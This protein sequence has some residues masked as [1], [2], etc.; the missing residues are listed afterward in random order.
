MRVLHLNEHLDWVGG[1]ETYLLHLL[2]ALELQGVTCW[3]AYARGYHDLGKNAIHLPE[4]SQ[5]GRHAEESAYAKVRALIGDLK[6]DLVHIHR[7][8][9]LGAVEAC[10]EL[11]PTVVT[12]H[13]YLYLCPAGSF[14][15]RWTQTICNRQAGLGCFAVTALRHCMT[16]RPRYALAYFRRVET[17]VRWKDRFAVVLCPSDSVRQRLL[18]YGFGAERTC[19]LPYFCPL[20]PLNEPRPLP[21]HPTILFLGR[22]RP[23]KGYDVFIRA[24]GLLP[25]VRGILVGDITNGTAEKVSCLAKETGCGERLEIRP[26]ARRDQVPDLF[27]ETSVFTFPSIWPETLGIV[28]LEAMA[29][30]VP[31]AASDVGGVRQWLRDEENGLLVRPKDPGALAA[32]IDQMLVSHERLLAMGRSG[33]ATVRDGFLPSQHVERLLAIYQNAI[34]GGH[35]FNTE[36]LR[37]SK[38]A[39]STDTPQTVHRA[40]TNCS[41]SP[42]RGG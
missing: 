23:I 32:A 27:A 13:D 33:I 26:W 17:F 24:L 12:C 40:D 7:V 14:F 16:L 9:N 42:T 22:V 19:T 2:P 3:Y 10:L 25:G 11:R 4:L 20:E 28:G 29:C 37:L 21:D 6:P 8:Y 5:F 36:T 38:K 39:V 31:V 15:H 1:V 41:S 18:D 30:G 34:D 35:A